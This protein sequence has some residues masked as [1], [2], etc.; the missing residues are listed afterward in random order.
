MITTIR[1]FM[2]GLAFKL[3]APAIGLALMA[4]RGLSTTE[5]CYISVNE[6]S[7][8]SYICPV[9][10]L[11]QIDLYTDS[12]VYNP[13]CTGAT[14]GVMYGFDAN[15]QATAQDNADPGGTTGIPMSWTDLGGGYSDLEGTFRPEVA[16]YYA[17]VASLAVQECPYN[18]NYATQ[19]TTIIAYSINGISCVNTWAAP[20]GGA[21]NRT[22]VGVGEPSTLTLNVVPQFSP[23][24]TWSATSGTLS[25]QSSWSIT[26]TAPG[27]ADTPTVT[28]NWN[29]GM[30]TVPTTIGFGVVAPSSETAIIL[31]V[32]YPDTPPGDYAYGSGMRLEVTVNPQ[33]VCFGAVEVQEGAA[34]PTSL[35]GVFDGSPP[36]VTAPSHL[37]WGFWGGVSTA[38]QWGPDLAA[39]YTPFTTTLPFTVG[40]TTYTSG[41]FTW[42]IPA[43][44]TTY[45]PGGY[46]GSLPNHI[47]TTQFSSSWGEETKFSVTEPLANPIF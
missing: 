17:L 38:N 8:T 46:T 25:A 15:S 37:A 13:D 22:T 33:S 7:A 43:S 20:A 16:G 30:T 29:N 2:R 4:N 42:S 32:V 41:G 34:P 11:L 28:A 26:Y 5:N 19:Y 39:N 45:F 6:T 14:Y 1:R 10:T 31:G 24:I 40:S 36:F 23:S 3:V 18:Y 35:D 12:L 21:V 27:S 9:G 44:W 47:Q